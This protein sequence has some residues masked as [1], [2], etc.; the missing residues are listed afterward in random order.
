[1]VRRML[2]KWDPDLDGQC[3]S[4]E[5]PEWNTRRI[6][7]SFEGGTNAEFL[8]V[9]RTLEVKFRELIVKTGLDWGASDSTRM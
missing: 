4:L 6:Q 9:R 2:E 7:V 3:R 8:T 5:Y 1:M